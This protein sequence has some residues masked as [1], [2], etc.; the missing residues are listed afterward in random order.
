[1]QL[2]SFKSQLDSLSTILSLFTSLE[3]LLDITSL[4]SLFNANIFFITMDKPPTYEAEGRKPHNDSSSIAAT[5][6]M[7]DRDGFDC[8]NCEKCK[9]ERLLRD[10]E[11]SP[12]CQRSTHLET[13]TTPAQSP[14]A[15]K[16]HVHIKDVCA[17]GQILYVVVEKSL[18][19]LRLIFSPLFPPSKVI[20]SD[21]QKQSVAVKYSLTPSIL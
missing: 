21:F 8:E 2:R 9:L 15:P 3:I 20:V 18:P 11:H 16:S 13:E 1:L 7:V 6:T 19:F 10:M 12:T 17:C 5:K 4:P 14:A